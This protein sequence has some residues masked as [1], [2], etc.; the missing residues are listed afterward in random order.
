MS[1]TKY[2]QPKNKSTLQNTFLAKPRIPSQPYY[3]DKIGE[4]VG[5]QWL[6]MMT[7]LGTSTCN[8]HQNELFS[9]TRVIS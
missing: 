2:L 5:A 4:L 1:Q 7:T 8:L 6:N 3:F 9:T